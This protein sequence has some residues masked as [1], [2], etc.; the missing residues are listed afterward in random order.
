[1]AKRD[2]AA[3]AA[4]V[5]WKEKP[6]RTAGVK[7]RPLKLSLQVPPARIL[8]S[9]I[10]TPPPALTAVP[11]DLA[12]ALKARL[13]ARERRKVGVRVHSAVVS[14][15]PGQSPPVNSVCKETQNYSAGPACGVLHVF[16]SK[17]S[18]AISG[19]L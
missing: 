9:R 5:R 18:D 6:A 4:S 12:S 8:N 2:V 13:A 11:T 16:E 3:A 19:K 14:K 10:R 1:M 7:H 17:N 15:T